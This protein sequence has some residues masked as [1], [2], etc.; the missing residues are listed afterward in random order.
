MGKVIVF[1]VLS[2]ALIFVLVQGFFS[3]QDSFST[4]MVAVSSALLTICISQYRQAMDEITKVTD[5]EL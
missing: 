3:T 1:S 5:E 4:L 2:I